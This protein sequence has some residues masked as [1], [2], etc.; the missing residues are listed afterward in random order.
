MS[1][2]KR[3]PLELLARCE[4][5]GCTVTPTRKGWQVKAPGGKGIAHVHLTPS[6]HRATQNTLRDLRRI[7]VEL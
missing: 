5:A 6:D 3:A 4:A 7:G 2:K 1:T